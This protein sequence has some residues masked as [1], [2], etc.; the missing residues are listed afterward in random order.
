MINFGALTQLG[1]L[2]KTFCANHPKVPAFVSDLKAKG[3]CAGQEIAVAVRYPD[4]SEVK[5]GIRVTESDLELLRTLASL[6]K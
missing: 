5:T 3:F 4:G 1:S 2:Y 6:K